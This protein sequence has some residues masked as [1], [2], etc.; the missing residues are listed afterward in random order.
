MKKLILMTGLVV[1]LAA[2]NDKKAGKSLPM[3][4]TLDSF[5]YAI[6]ANIGSGLHRS[7]I[8]EV[9]WDIFQGALQEAL[10]RGDSG[11]AMEESV[12]MDIINNYITDASYGPNKKEGSDYIAKNKADYKVQESGLLFKQTKAGNGIKPTLTD[13]VLITYTGKYVDGTIFDSNVGK[14]TFKTSLNGGAIPGFLEALTLMEEGSEA[15]VIIP[16]D[17]AYGKN[18]SRNPYSGEMR[19]EPYKTLVFTLKIDSIQK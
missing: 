11:L 4:N 15:E 8:T 7:K 18:G 3:T 2:C 14:E 13:T 9:N 17:I 10:K 1:F 16:Y 6:G 12:M 5:S 19:I